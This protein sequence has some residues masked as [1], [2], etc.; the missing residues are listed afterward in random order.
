MGSG[1]S[2]LP[3]GD[4]GA[5]GQSLVNLLSAVQNAVTA[6]NG[7]NQT[8][9]LVFPGATALSTTAPSSVGTVTFTSSEPKGFISITT[10]SGYQGK[11][12]V[13]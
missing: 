12:A 2:Q 11:V 4:A 8:L 1:F 9:G 5:G 7:L 10:S 6:I 13:Y 3:N